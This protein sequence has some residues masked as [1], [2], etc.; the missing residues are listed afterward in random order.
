MPDKRDPRQS[1]F[2][3]C[4]QE[5]ADTLAESM[6]ALNDMLLNEYVKKL[7]SA[8]WQVRAKSAR[9]LGSLQSV[10][11]PTIPVLEGLLA[12]KDHRVRKAAALALASIR[13]AG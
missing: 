9:G 7:K 13:A 1:E 5:E 3:C 4:R 12:D 11:V 2:D 6:L 10:A 8:S